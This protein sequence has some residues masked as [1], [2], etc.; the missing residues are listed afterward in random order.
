MD[1][2]GGTGALL[3]LDVCCVYLISVCFLVVKMEALGV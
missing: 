3:R 1:P 2:E